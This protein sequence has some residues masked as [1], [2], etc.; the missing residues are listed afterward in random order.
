MNGERVDHEFISRQFLRCFAQLLPPHLEA[1]LSGRGA[2]GGLP[3]NR[4]I[5]SYFI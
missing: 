5:F 1:P 4:I 2:F 3:M